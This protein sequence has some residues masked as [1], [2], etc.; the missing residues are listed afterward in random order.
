MPGVVNNKSARRLPA[1]FL[2]VMLVLATVT[3]SVLALRLGAAGISAEHTLA[4]VARRLGLIDGSQVTV[5]QD[6][7][8]WQLRMPRVLAALAIGSC[9]AI[10]GVVLQALTNNELADPYLLGISSGASVGAVTVIVFGVSLPMVAQHAAIPAATFVGAVAATTLVLI[11]ARG[12]SGYLPPGRTILSGVAIAQL[13]GAYTSMAI[14]VFGERGSA[15]TVLTWTLG[16]LAGVRWFQAILLLVVTLVALV[17]MAGA[18]R[19]L[20]AFSFGDNAAET[21]GI[22]VRRA[23]WLLL[24]ATSLITATTV[25]VAGPIG[26]VGL[27]VPHLVRL[28]VGPRHGVL[29]PLSAL[30]G[31]FLL[32]AS[33]TLARSLRAGAELPIGVVTA[34]VG[35]PLLIF[36]LRRQAA[37]S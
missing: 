1:A 14:M 36:L 8:V 22:N 30:A 23:R 35:A 5:F 37:R 29:L 4:V 27:T 32:L 3:L 31:A 20:D 6:Q 12:K 11:L 15:G 28:V 26:F 13:C 34:V 21:L 24:I 9:L 2:G 7:I 10:C 17:V 18:A 33:D 25:A 19:V 16:S